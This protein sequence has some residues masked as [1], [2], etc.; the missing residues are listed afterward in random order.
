[1]NELA[2]LN[3]ILKR[4]GTGHIQYVFRES[5]HTLIVGWKLNKRQ[6]QEL[7]DMV[8]GTLSVTIDNE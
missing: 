1:M 7:S 3:K 8:A 4:Y 5:G 6:L 2:S